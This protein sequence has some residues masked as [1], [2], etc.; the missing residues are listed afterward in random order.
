MWTAAPKPKTPLTRR[1]RLSSGLHAHCGHGWQREWIEGFLRPVVGKTGTTNAARDSGLLAHYRI[2]HL[3][4]GLVLITAAHSERRN[5][6]AYRCPDCPDIPREIRVEW[7]RL[8]AWPEEITAVDI[9]TDG[10]LA[11]E[12]AEESRREFFGRH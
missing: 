2:H 5:L 3:P 11:P 12:G 1:S 6:V 8:E 9:V 4:L 7:R 10:R